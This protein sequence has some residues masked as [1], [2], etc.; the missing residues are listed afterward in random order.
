[1]IQ[2]KIQ[3]IGVVRNDFT[4]PVDPAMIRSRESKLVMKEK[5]REGLKGLEKHRFIEVVYL[6]HQE[7]E[8]ALTAQN[9]HGV[10]TGVFATRQT[11]RPSKIGISTVHLLGVDKRVIRVIG[12]D[13]LNGSPV[14]DIKPSER[15]YEREE[16]SVIQPYY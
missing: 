4:E 7:K 3:Q 8:T 6:F 15:F 14:L 5:F 10:S 13:A 11:C 9:L 1:M 12:L 16:L 2:D